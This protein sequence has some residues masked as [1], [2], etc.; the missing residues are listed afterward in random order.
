M[1]TALVVLAGFAAGCAVLVLLALRL[2]YTVTNSHLNITLFRLP[3]RRIRLADIDRVSKRQ[4]RVAERWMNTLR[5][6][7]RVLVIRRRRG[8]PRELIITPANRYVFKAVLERA[9]AGLH[10]LEFNRTAASSGPRRPERE[11]PPSQNS[12]CQPGGDC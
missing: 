1:K 6:S 12:A 8:W 4:S 7:H 9:V 10:P 11:D 5:P 2:R 3:V